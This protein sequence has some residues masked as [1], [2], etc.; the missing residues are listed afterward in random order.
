MN[1]K[2]SD[3]PEKIYSDGTRGDDG[4]GKQNC[5]EKG[6][7]KGKSD[8]PTENRYGMSSATGCKDQKR[9]KN[10]WERKRRGRT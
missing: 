4:M 10:V 3:A 2:A 5:S 6:N 1:R 8:R 7:E 9:E